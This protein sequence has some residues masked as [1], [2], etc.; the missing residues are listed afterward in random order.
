[1]EPASLSVVSL[2]IFLLSA[3]SR[4]GSGFCSWS[5]PTRKPAFA[6]RN[7]DR[8]SSS[9][10]RPRIEGSRLH[11]SSF[12]ADGSEYSSKDKSDFDDEDDKS[13]AYG[14]TYKDDDQDDT[15]TIEM[16]PVPLSKNAGNRFV[17]LIWDREL[18]G[19]S[20][21]DALDLHNDRIQLTE[22]HV[23]FCRKANLYNETFNT[24]SNVDVRFSLPMYVICDRGLCV[25][26]FLER[27][28][29]CSLSVDL[30]LPQF[31]F[32]LSNRN[33]ERLSS[34]LK[35]VIGHV[36]CLESEKLEDAR[37]LLSRDPIVKM[38]TGGNLDDI[39][40]YRWRHIRDHSLRIDDGRFGY[41]CMCLAL[42]EELEEVGNLRGEVRDDMLEYL[43]R[44]ERVIAAGPLH[45]PTEL[46]D[47]PSSIPVGASS[48]LYC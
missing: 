39:P 11:Q 24:E 23:M 3:L 28:R 47:D 48:V 25:Y 2:L 21:K 35:R 10:K 15:P 1:M 26:A 14:R 8:G 45:L 22:D 31:S 46:K 40:F 7:C 34:D 27:N 5:L 20:S 42:D 36:M 6:R 33:N 13:S 17:A 12:T 16:E 30:H 32:V 41:P 38:L 9:R 29:A 37:A 18:A 43:I 19:D 44:S 4:S